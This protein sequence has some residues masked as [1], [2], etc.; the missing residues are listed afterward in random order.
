M[1]EAETNFGMSIAD[2]QFTAT[3]DITYANE[4]LAKALN[5]DLGTPIIQRKWVSTDPKTNRLLSTSVSYIP[6]GVFI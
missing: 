6:K 2:Q 1:G 3:Y 5:V 4:E